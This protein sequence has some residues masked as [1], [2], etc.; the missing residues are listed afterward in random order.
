M[1]WTELDQAV[2]Q[3]FKA[4]GGDFS[5]EEVR[6]ELHGFHPLSA[7]VLLFMRGGVYRRR[8][9]PD[10]V[11][12]SLDISDRWIETLL[13]VLGSLSKPGIDE[14][15]ATAYSQVPRVHLLENFERAVT[16]ADYLQIPKTAAVLRDRAMESQDSEQSRALVAFIDDVTSRWGR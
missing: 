14:E 11:K 8:F 16:V 2:G 1:S 12:E 13:E 4:C 3:L 5:D 7:L 6:Q 15:I 9:V 10:L